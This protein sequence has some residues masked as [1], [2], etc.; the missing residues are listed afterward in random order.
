MSKP[1]SIHCRGYRGVGQPWDENE[2]DC[3]ATLKL[4]EF[5]QRLDET[6]SRIAGEASRQVHSECGQ[7]IVELEQRL[8][9]AESERVTPGT[10]LAVSELH[11]K[12]YDLRQMLE[13]ATDAFDSAM[14][15]SYPNDCWRE[16]LLSRDWY[17]AA[18]KV[19]TTE[20]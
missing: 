1:H 4:A 6:S 14:A 3:G 7:R 20:E 5:K 9:V 2:C 18:R 13:V 16:A 12:I 8:A 10:I 15:N 19:T 17:E 11:G